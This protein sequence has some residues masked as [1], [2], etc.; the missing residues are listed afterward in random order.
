MDAHV[1]PG[2][3]P[4]HV[5]SRTET[6]QEGNQTQKHE[7][8]EKSFKNAGGYQNMKMNYPTKQKTMDTN[9]TL[10]QFLLELLMDQQNGTLITWTGVEGEFKLLNAEEVARQW[11]LKKNKNNMNYDKLSRALRYYYDKNIIKKVMG[12]KFVYKFVSFPEIVKTENKIPF[13]VKM[14]SLDMHTRPQSTS[15]TD[16]IHERKCESVRPIQVREAPTHIEHLT[17]AA[18]PT[19]RT[20]ESGSMSWTTSGLPTFKV[21]EPQHSM[22]YSPTAV[23]LSSRGYTSDARMN[24]EPTLVNSSGRPMIS[25]GSLATTMTTFAS[26]T[27]PTPIQLSVDSPSYSGMYL[28]TPVTSYPGVTQGAATPIMI[29]SPLLS[30]NGTPLLPLSFWNTLSPMTLSP[31][32]STLNTFQFPTVINGHHVLPMQPLTP[33]VLLSPSTTKPIIVS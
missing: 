10:W 3:T 28:S 12:Q 21:N 13:K 18:P 16:Q 19:D 29:A 32:M 22:V 23:T 24:N 7:I 17:T 8:T 33:T 14:E 26:R 9:V 31:S 2:Y 20:S 1:T 15:T 30:Q 25:T 4:T 27:K 6:G 11:G 5:I